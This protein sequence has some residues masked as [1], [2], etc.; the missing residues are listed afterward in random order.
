[1][2]LLSDYGG[3]L[4]LH[5][6][7][8]DISAMA[9]VTKMDDENF[10][11]AYWR[12]RA[13]YDRADL[14]L[15]AYWE[16]VLGYKPSLE[17]LTILDDLDAQGWAHEN[18][19]T[20]QRYN[21]LKGRLD[22]ALLSNAPATLARRIER[23]SWMPKMRSMFFSC[24]LRL[25]KPSPEIYERVLHELDTPPELVLFVDDR[26]EN[27]E[28]AGSMGMKTILFRDATDLKGAEEL[29]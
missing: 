8:S 20:V 16:H 13:E 15:E 24:D 9:K 6:S 4:C 21:D 29:T 5:Q 2:W 3:V 18:R 26:L 22:L 17:M 27:V 1:M 7:P 11:D 25:T 10:T 28:A 14:S 19:A 23:L 12:Y